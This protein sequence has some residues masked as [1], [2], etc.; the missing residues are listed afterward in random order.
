MPAGGDPAR[1]RQGLSGRGPAAAAERLGRCALAAGG[2]R[3]PLLDRR[4]VFRQGAIMRGCLR[5]QKTDVLFPF[6]REVY[7]DGYV[8]E[9]AANRAIFRAEPVEPERKAARGGG[10]K[11][12]VKRAARRAK[13]RIRALAHCADLRYFVTLTLD[14]GKV[15]RYDAREVV[16]RMSTWCDNQVRRKGLVYVLVPELHRDGAVHFHGLFNCAL[17][18]V[19]SGTIIRASGGRPMRPRSD[20][21]RRALLDAG[22]HI[23]YNLPGWTLG[24][25]TAI[26][27]YGDRARAIGYVTKYIGKQVNTGKIAGRWYYH[28]GAFAEPAVSYLDITARDVCDGMP[29]SWYKLEVPEAGLVMM[30]REFWN[31]KSDV[32]RQDLAGGCADVGLGAV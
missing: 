20:R 26:E 23:V 18:A 25:T 8:V 31:E 14:G 12:D 28:G 9:T 3:A 30:R 11:S 10:G 15:D 7:P 17:A 2:A 24:Y 1:D 27:L 32:N 22:G 5:V 6:K 19:D 13:A 4:T 21:Q 16:R 29:G